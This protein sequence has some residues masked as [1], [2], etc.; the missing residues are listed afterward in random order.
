[1]A[2]NLKYITSNKPFHNFSSTVMRRNIM[3]EN[4]VILSKTV[5][6]ELTRL[7]EILPVAIS[8]YE[9]RA[10]KWKVQYFNELMCKLTGYSRDEYEHKVRDNPWELIYEEDIRL[11]CQKLDDLLEEGGVVYQ[12]CRIKGKEGKQ[13]V[14]IWSK[15]IGTKGESALVH[16]VYADI[17]DTYDTIQKLLIEKE[18]NRIINGLLERSKQYIFKYY[19]NT[20]TYI[21]CSDLSNQFVFNENDKFTLETFLN[22]D[23]IAPESLK[24][25]AI[26]F[27]NIK[28]GIPNGT[29]TVKAKDDFGIWQWYRIKYYTVFD[30][31]LIP[32][33][34]IIYF[35]NI[36]S[37]RQ[38]SIE[39]KRFR[40]FSMIGSSHIFFNVTYNLSLDEFED[41]DGELPI[42]FGF[43]PDQS[44]DRNVSII[45]ERIH[46]QDLRDFYNFL[47][48]RRILSSF[49][50]GI[51]R[52]TCDFRV[53]S[54]NKYIW[55]KI[56]YH[57]LEDPY[58]GN[59][60]L[61]LSCKKIDDQKQSEI[62]LMTNAQRD[63]L[64][65]VYNRGTFREKVSE[66]L[67]D[68]NEDYFSAIILADLDNFTKVNELFGYSFGDKVIRDIA[69]TMRLII[70]EEDVLG[71]ISGTRFILYLHNNQDLETVE[72]RLEL[73]SMAVSRAT[74]DSLKLSVS[75]GISLYG[76]DGRDTDTLYEKADLAL[77]Y[78]KETGRNKY[79][80]YKEKLKKPPI[81]NLALTKEFKQEEYN[82]ISVD[83]RTFGYFDVFINGQ[84]ILIPHGKAKELLALLVHRRGGFVT[85]Q[86][87]IAHLWEDEEANKVTMARVRKVFMLLRDTL[88]EYGVEEII[89]SNKGARRIV[90]E[91]VNCDLYNFLSGDIKYS[92][93]FKGYYMLN[94]SWGEFAMAELEQQD[95]TY[96]MLR[97]EPS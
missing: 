83:I 10:G 6:E 86:E 38:K 53:K 16:S 31:K 50:K 95:E 19:F 9:Y 54:F 17:T 75:M 1:M 79:I 89:E 34:S 41:I 42:D 3:A 96:R 80:F 28:S 97:E 13:V 48:T 64:T 88:K 24:D 93:L 39:A 11:L 7:Y 87:I 15:I 73:I 29:T 59:F 32:K 52:G 45:G 2:R 63:E 77:S 60:I 33:Y 25:L 21:L 36:T 81:N 57:I 23:I 62:I 20:D 71:R 22:T 43:N 12:Q 56:T 68:V 72:K 47:S 14:N 69:R 26:F 90:P 18:D 78:A 91:R 58:S 40:D 94:Y 85:P 30:E 74:N 5:L 82:N 46:P 92:N 66:K 27:R 4:D 67:R 84:A 8:V 61:W 65:G 70:G 49:S 44:L 76:K 37:S 51:N 55:V 35:R